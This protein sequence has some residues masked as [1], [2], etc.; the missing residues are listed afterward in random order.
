MFRA[1][2]NR[3]TLPAKAGTPNASQLPRSVCLFLLFAFSVQATS[4][5]LASII[6]T[7]GQRG[8]ELEISLTGDRLQDAEEII[9]YE[10]GIQI[11]KLSS[12][13]NKV[14]KAEV[15]LT[16]DCELGE[17]H[18]RVRTTTGLSELRTFF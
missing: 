11:L 9:C 7:G 6:P 13:T 5:H 8:S 16:S 4:P 1:T 3:D 2:L 10:K 15:K 17:H 14:V 18:L 12:V